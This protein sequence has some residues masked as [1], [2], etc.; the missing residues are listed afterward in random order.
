MDFS[1]PLSHNRPGSCR[2]SP[3]HGEFVVSVISHQVIV[4]D[5]ASLEVR[6]IF[7]CDD[8]VAEVEWSGDATYLLCILQNQKSVQIWS[9]LDPDWRCK[10]NEPVTGI[11]AA[12]W[13][14]DS[15]HVITFADFQ[16]CVYVKDYY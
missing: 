3:V 11:V 16:V 13:T 14:P 15:R 2:W 8:N 9:I 4:Q 6:H 7:S 5:A 10:I 12:L 1:E